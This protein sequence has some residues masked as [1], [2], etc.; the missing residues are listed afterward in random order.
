MKPI[1]VTLLLVSLAGNAALAVF[2]LRP[3]SP[4][5][6]VAQASPAGPSAPA[7]T[8]ASADVSAAPVN[9]QTLKPGP[10][11][12]D[13]VTNLRAAGFPPAVIRAIMNQ[14]VADRLA[15]PGMDELPF[16]KRNFNNPEYRAAQE[17]LNTDR[18]NL[19]AELLGPDARPAATMD[20]VSRERRYGSLSD[21]K[22]DQIETL[23]RDF[24]EM[25]TKLLADRKPGDIQNPMAVQAGLEQELQKELAAVLTP[26]E[27]E[28]YEMRSSQAASRVMAN[29]RSVDVNETEYAALFRAQKAFEAADPSRQGVLGVESMAQRALAQEQLNEQAR[30]VLT[31]DRF[32]EYLK[33]ADYEYAR[34]AQFAAK[35]PSIT[36]AMTY[37]LTQIER[38]NQTAMVTMSRAGAGAS[39]GDRMAQMTAARQAYQAKLTNLL[40]TEAAAAYANRNRTGGTILPV[41]RFGP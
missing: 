23:N 41:V 28:Q 17:Q 30:A 5:V 6:P 4:A 1:L 19:L 39:P 33:S 2:A 37:E 22:I 8:P 15:N 24:S 29:L 14:M 12:H 32:Y 20:P 9:W 11:L 21:D 35:Y 34:A 13:L 27:L 26:A 40:G 3:K 18:R 36:P 10:N 31:D 16:W 7:T 25:R 38:E